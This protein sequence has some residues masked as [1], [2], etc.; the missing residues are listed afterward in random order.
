MAG[1]QLG[2]GGG[3]M[4]TGQIDTCITFKRNNKWTRKPVICFLQDGASAG[5]Q[6]CSALTSLIL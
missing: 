4:V 5:M 3:G 1:C 6:L 2:G